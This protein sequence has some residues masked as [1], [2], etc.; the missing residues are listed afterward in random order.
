MIPFINRVMRKD[1]LFLVASLW[2][3]RR[4]LGP[5]EEPVF[6]RA[7]L[8]GSTQQQDAERL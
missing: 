2:S 3:V 5:W 6:D 7:H 8:V 4:T 1:R